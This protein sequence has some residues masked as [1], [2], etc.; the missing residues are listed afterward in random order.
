M[1]SSPQGHS[2]SRSLT[3]H[4][5]KG[6]FSPPKIKASLFSK[7]MTNENKRPRY[8]HGWKQGP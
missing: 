3:D 5:H 8:F 2:L 1:L 4:S 6:E 7:S